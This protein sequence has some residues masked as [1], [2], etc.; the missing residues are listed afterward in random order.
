MKTEDLAAWIGE[1][2]TGERILKRVN[3][4]EWVLVTMV[5]GWVAIFRK[6]GGELRPAIQAASIEKAM[7]CI[8]RFEPTP[9]RGQRLA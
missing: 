1:N 2:G 4:I 3:G 6:E 7:D 8:V 9:A 5:D